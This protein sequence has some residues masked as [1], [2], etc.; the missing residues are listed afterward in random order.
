MSKGIAAIA[1]GALAAF[2]VLA[3]LLGGGFAAMLQA[4][5]DAKDSV[6]EGTEESDSSVIR[7]MG[8]LVKWA[9]PGVLALLTFAVGAVLLALRNR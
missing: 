9:I 4:S 8:L 7:V 3:V 5:S 2:I 6:E 1:S